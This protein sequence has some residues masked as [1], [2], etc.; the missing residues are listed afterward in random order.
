MT[1][2]LRVGGTPRVCHTI[3][4]N[5]IKE[6]EKQITYITYVFNNTN[7]LKEKQITGKSKLQELSNPVDF[8]TKK[9]DTYE[10]KEREEIINN[11]TKNVSRLAQKVDDA[12]YCMEFL[13]SN[14]KILT[15]S[16][17]KQ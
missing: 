1:C 13:K 16:V 4:L 3:L 12:S 11:L 14:K 7:K 5:S 17:S 8:I 2:L 9:F 10:R 15:S 6:V